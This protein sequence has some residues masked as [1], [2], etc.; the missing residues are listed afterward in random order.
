[1]VFFREQNDVIMIIQ[2]RSTSIVF[3]VH[4]MSLLKK[5]FYMTVKKTILV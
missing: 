3:S 5:C 4:S 2:E 1:M